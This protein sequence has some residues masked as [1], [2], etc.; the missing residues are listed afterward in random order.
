MILQKFSGWIG[1]KEPEV[2]E[3]PGKTLLE[4]IEEAQKDWQYA[5]RMYQEATD[6][7]NIDA[8]IHKINA[9]ERHYMYLLKLARYENI[10]AFPDIT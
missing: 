10:S 7:D 2:V 8:L 5:K 9:S 3:S 6:K 1:I 4:A